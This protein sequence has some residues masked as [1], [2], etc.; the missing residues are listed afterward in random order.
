MSR[1]ITRRHELTVPEL[2]QSVPL[3]P[4]TL[5]QSIDQYFGLTAV[6]D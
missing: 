5:S 4:P 6:E 3:Q 1:D 2:S